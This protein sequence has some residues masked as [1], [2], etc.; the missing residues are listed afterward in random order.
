M[1][2]LKVKPDVGYTKTIY[3]KMPKCGHEIEFNY[4]T[5]FKCQEAG[6]D[7][8]PEQI[9]RLYGEHSMA[10]RVRYFAEGKIG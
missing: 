6:C 4:T 10:A 3:Y 8:K 9:D 5:P 1:L 7:E 2:Q